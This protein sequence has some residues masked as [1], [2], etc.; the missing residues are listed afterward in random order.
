VK[1]YDDARHALLAKWDQH[2]ASS[3]GRGVRRDTVGEDHVERNG[4]GDIA[5]FGHG[6]RG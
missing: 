4:D 1:F 5:E 3:D 2:A 6:F